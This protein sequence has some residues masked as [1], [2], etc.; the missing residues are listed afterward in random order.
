MEY[1]F[2]IALAVAW[3]VVTTLACCDACR[4]ENVLRQYIA[5]SVV[6]LACC[7]PCHDENALRQYVALICRYRSAQGTLP[8]QGA[9]YG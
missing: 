2:E 1:P 9:R 4:G 3:S 6:T 5:W 7:D 8:G